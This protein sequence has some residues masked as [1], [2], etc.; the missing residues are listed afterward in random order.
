M[1]IALWIIG[2]LSFTA[3]VIFLSITKGGDRD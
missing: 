2:G 1:S 3:F